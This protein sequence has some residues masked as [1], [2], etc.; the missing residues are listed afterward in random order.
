M[1]SLTI[2]C[3]DNS[4][5]CSN[6]TISNSSNTSFAGV[7]I[8]SSK[9][10]GYYYGD[11]CHPWSAPKSYLDWKVAS[12]ASFKLWQTY[13]AASASKII[14]AICSHQSKTPITQPSSSSAWEQTWSIRISSWFKRE[15]SVRPD[16]NK[17]PVPARQVAHASGS[18]LSLHPF[19][20]AT[21]RERT[22][23]AFILRYWQLNVFWQVD[24]MAQKPFI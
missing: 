12:Q 9:K 14:L 24:K 18:S 3:S 5:S 13:D 11:L 22:K 2:E 21:T 19:V 1:D 10:I 4:F 7:T 8:P 17:A 20:R 23:I 15:S 16:A 6:V